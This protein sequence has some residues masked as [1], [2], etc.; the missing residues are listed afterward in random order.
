MKSVDEHL[1]DILSVVRPLDPLEVG[2]LD[3]HGCVLA[4]D[5]VAS[6][7]VPPY[8]VASVDGYAVRSGDVAGAPVALPVVGDVLAGTTSPLTVQQGLCVR[9]GAGA[10]LPAGA[11]AVVPSTWTDSGLAQVRIDRPAPAGHGV[12][13]AGAEVTAG[14]TVLSAGSHLGAAQIGLAAGIGQARLQVRPRPRVVVLASG[15]ELVEP[16]APLGPGQAYDS[17]TLS[18]TTACLEA[19]AIAY[20]VGIVPDDGRSLRDTL[21]DQ[22]VRA[23]L[24]LLGAGVSAGSYDAIREV[25]GRLGQVAFQDVAMD[26]GALHGFGVIGPDATPVF[27]LPGDPLGAQVSFEAF[28]RPAIR[29]M[30]GVP[31]IARPM[32]SARAGADLT[33]P[34]G[35]RSFLRA[36]LEVKDGAYVVTPADARSKVSGLSRANALAV[37]PES[38]EQVATGSAV[39]VVMLERRGL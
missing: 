22:L 29:R 28:V 34:A 17:N 37:V 2:L 25:L 24:I 39:Q 4:Q 14:E 1:A 38:V 27:G 33:S 10:L 5:V 7:P 12:V 23:D 16:G 9:I 35:R 11:D 21:E 6:A 26:P 31:H 15:N 19:G 3:A 36:W 18:L 20:R 13:L 8:D 32:V 30:L